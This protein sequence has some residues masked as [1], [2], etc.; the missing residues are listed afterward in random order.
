MK[1]YGLIGY[2]LGHSFS[3]RFFTEK[4]SRE[5]IDAVYDN[6]EL[7]D[8]NMLLDVVENHPDLEGLNC[9]I[10][11]KQAVMSLLD[12]ISPEASK[13]GAVNVIKILRKEESSTA[14]ARGYKLIGYNSD[15]IG[16]TES[17]RPLL[18]PCH[19]RALVL[20]TGGAAQ[21]I[22]VALGNLGIEWKYV[23]R[24]SAQGRFSYDQIT[25]DVLREYLVVINCSPVGM[26]PHVNEAPQLPYDALTANHLL[27]DLVYNPLETKFLQYG[28]QAGA[29]VKNGLEMLELQALASWDIWTS[30]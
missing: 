13:I 17:I 7:P 25:S 14:D 27:Y 6:Y 24:T 23:S 29:V 4:F 10:P 19:K 1:Q 3:K 12:E 8:V 9:T 26:F 16:F 18:K 28:A 11:H 30:K 20:G 22:T 15:I 21:A 2:P 5:G